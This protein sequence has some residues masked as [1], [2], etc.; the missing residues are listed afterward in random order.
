MLPKVIFRGSRRYLWAD[1]PDRDTVE[2]P[3]Y[4]PL[5]NEDENLVCQ[6]EIDENSEEFKLDPALRERTSDNIYLHMK[7]EWPMRRVIFPVHHR[8]K[9]KSLRKGSARPLQVEG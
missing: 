9:R 3:F 5:E 4:D 1:T 8:R 7:S 2:P 6:D